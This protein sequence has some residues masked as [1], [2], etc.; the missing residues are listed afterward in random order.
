MLLEMKWLPK[1]FLMIGFWLLF[2]FPDI[3]EL[4]RL[5]TLW[6]GLS[7]NVFNV[8]ICQPYITIERS[9]DALKLNADSQ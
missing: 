5:G 8:I 7:R 1:S 6:R 4:S 2:V 9:R 3:A